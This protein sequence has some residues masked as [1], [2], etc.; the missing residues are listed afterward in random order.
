ML[1][2]VNPVSKFKGGV[3][4][5]LFDSEVSQRLCYCNRDEVYLTTQL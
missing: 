3:I 5:V 1:I 4:L 2:G